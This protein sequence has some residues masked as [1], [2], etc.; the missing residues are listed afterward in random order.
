MSNTAAH[1]NFEDEKSPGSFLPPFDS[2][3][4]LFE[5][6]KKTTV[7]QL[8]WPFVLSCCYLLLST[9]NNW[10]NPDQT[11]AILAVYLL[12]NAALYFTHD[13]RFDSPR[14]SGGLLLFDTSFL[15]VALAL[16]G[17]GTGDFYFICFM[18][19]AL[20]CLCNDS[21]GLLII[22][23]L[24]PVIYGYFVFNNSG[25]YDSGIYLRLIFPFVIS[26]FYGYFAQVERLKRK[27]KEGEAHARERQ[28]AAETIQRET[29]LHLRR[30]EALR[31]IDKA[32]NS[33]LELEA[34]LKLL[35][36]KIDAFLSFSVATTIRLFNQNTGKFENTACRNIDETSW[37]KQVGHGTG[38]LSAEILRTKLP[39]IVRDIQADPQ[40][41]AVEF[42]R[43]HGFVSYLGVPLIV[44]EEVV[45]ILGFYTTIIHDFRPEEIDFLLT[46][47][48]QAAIAIHNSQ[49]YEQIGRSNAELEKTTQ[50]L[51]RSLKQL[52]GL[53][54]ALTPISA[55]SSIEEML[56]GIL[57]RLLDAT[58]ADAGLIRMHD[59]TT[60]CY[61]IMSQRNFSADYIEKVEASR[62]SGAVDWVVR[63]DEP[64][65]APDI[66]SDTRLKGK[67][68]LQLGLHSC[69]M[70]PLKVHNQVR[71]IIHIASRKRGYFQEREKDH[72]TTIARQMSITLE[73]RELFDN[74]K[75]SGDELARANQV[76][77]EFLSVMSH[78]LRTPLNL[79]MGYADTLKQGVFGAVNP[80][81]EKVLSKL[82][83]HSKEL[84]AM[85][86]AILY[87]I[88]IE[89]YETKRECD[90]FSLSEFLA[91]IEV[92]FSSQNH[93]QINLIWD[94][95]RNLPLMQTDREK[96]EH[97]LRNLIANAIKFT[98]GGCVVVSVR[99]KDRNHSSDTV[100]AQS[101]EMGLH[102]TDVE[103]KVSDTGTGIPPDKL[104]LIFDMFSQADSSDTRHHEGVGLGLYIV[105]HFTELLGGTIEVESELNRGSTFTV[106]IPRVLSSA[107]TK[108]GWLSADH[109]ITARDSTPDLNRGRL[110]EL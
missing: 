107:R 77:D 40:R 84:L 72:L 41:S 29:E 1:K 39:M 75:A 18:S 11:H 68:Q 108:V 42:Y 95:P 59:K 96:L 32:I 70:L 9:S 66:A 12:T 7:I 33:T 81:Q 25:H 15:V 89:D 6:A 53:H 47:G 69:A 60:N 8:R 44:K 17:W 90:Q 67:V 65:I 21:R 87:A 106:N 98:H 34:V 58:G 64:I 27:A 22:T 105:K 2:L 100:L 16:S 51:E 102:V 45:G 5:G 43:T 99:T 26:M 97:I 31:E 19:V 30:I 46:L 103:F 110:D 92:F 71:G 109:L 83:S 56:T 23:F 36:Q 38:N 61:R 50:Y 88:N 14:F 13:K 62:L 48:G 3:D 54:T 93:Q 101:L 82:L 49:L 74:L 35:L 86:N 55:G 24:T 73:N 4:R 78:E 52:T 104:P 10:L 79:V 94:Y 57:D 63:H 76:K 80:E 91:G 20:S 28:E 85:I 37:K